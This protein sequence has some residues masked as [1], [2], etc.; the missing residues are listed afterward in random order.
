MRALK[1]FSLFGF[2]LALLS[3]PP[4]PAVAKRAPQIV[5]GNT[6]Q[7]SGVPRSDMLHIRVR[8]DEKADIVADI[9]ADGDSIVASGGLSGIG[10]NTWAHISYKDHN[11]WVL[12]RYLKPYDSTPKTL[13]ELYENGIAVNYL[14][15]DIEI[16][17][18]FKGVVLSHPHKCPYPMG[19][20]VL[21]AQLPISKTLR[22]ENGV[23]T[24]G[25][26]D[27][28]ISSEMLEHFKARGFS[29]ETLCLGLTT[30]LSYNP[31]SGARVPSVGLARRCDTWRELG[32][33]LDKG[34]CDADAYYSVNL[35]L[36]DCFK[37]GTPLL[38]CR[39]SYHW[40]WRVAASGPLEKVKANEA[41]YWAKKA[42]TLDSIMKKLLQPGARELPNLLDRKAFANLTNKEI[43]S[44]IFGQG[45]S[46]GVQFIVVSKVF[47]RGY[48]YRIW[49]GHVAGE[50]PE[51][52]RKAEGTKGK[53]VL[54][55]ADM[56]AA[57]P[58]RK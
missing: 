7:V 5:A 9:P 15:K 13:S 51:E 8:P 2:L 1:A 46:G 33:D 20:D 39:M 41:R 54:T 40:F 6:Y 10:A 16:E 34:W 36:P 3:I 11:G 55:S 22:V 18:R 29:L 47:P 44:D 37:N 30:E 57:V 24:G 27:I 19:A 49:T 38:D 45:P 21:S 53:Q 43:A 31:E 42:A 52:E 25:D 4:D 48:A 58:W 35:N 50:D 14:R 17:G 23:L 26:I 28:S 12:A 56:R 32:L